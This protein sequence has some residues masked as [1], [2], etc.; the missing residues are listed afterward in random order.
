MAKRR[1]GN[2][3]IP[4]ANSHNRRSDFRP[5]S[6]HHEVN[7]KVSIEMQ[8]SDTAETGDINRFYGKGLKQ[9]GR[10]LPNTG[11]EQMDN[12]DLYMTKCANKH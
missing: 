8:V 1:I 5:K 3:D 11:E 12:V 4:E 9:E 6:I 10:H 2:G 7:L